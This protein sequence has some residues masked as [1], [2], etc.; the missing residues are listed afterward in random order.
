MDGR[1]LLLGLLGAAAAG[2][3]GGGGSA[4]ATATAVAPATSAVVPPAPSL[5]T[6]TVPAPVVV[7]SQPTPGSRWLHVSNGIQ[8]TQITTYALDAVSGLPTNPQDTAIVTTLEGIGKLACD[9]V[10][11]ILYASLTVKGPPTISP[12]TRPGVLLPIAI[13]NGVLAPGTPIASGKSDGGG[14]AVAPSGGSVYMSGSDVGTFILVRGG[15]VS[16]F[17]A[18]PSG[19]L[20]PLNPSFLA[21]G[22]AAGELAFDPSGSFVFCANRADDTVWSF[23]VQHGSLAPVAGSP[24]HTPAGNPGAANHDAVAIA[25]HPTGKF[26]YTGNSDTTLSVFQNANGVLTPTQSLAANASIWG[27]Y[28]I[29]IDPSGNFLY[30]AN[31]IDGTV[32]AF[33]IEPRT[34]LLTPLGQPLPLAG[35][36]PVDVVV[37]SSGHFLYVVDANQGVWALTIATDGTLAPVAGS[38]VALPPGDSLPMHAAVSP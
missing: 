10:N 5:P 36:E 2:C 4:P 11:Q 23:S 9:P 30:S 1:A 27:I 26:V 33:Q 8:T 16:S 13:N 7:P 28:A 6:S 24:F 21:A 19:G 20:T 34:G 17:G 25:V 31:G 15:G 3:Q 14:I 32:S 38:P 12:M 37:S 35:S 22:N 18:T 29:A